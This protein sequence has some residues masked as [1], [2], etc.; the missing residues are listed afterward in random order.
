MRLWGEEGVGTNG[1]NEASDAFNHLL[2]RFIVICLAVFTV[3]V[4]ANGVPP[5]MH[6]E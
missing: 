4:Q 2:F 5:V 1:G 3:T 6:S